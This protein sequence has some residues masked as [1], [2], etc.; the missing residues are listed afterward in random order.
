MKRPNIP[1]FKEKSDEFAITIQS[2][3]SELVDKVNGDI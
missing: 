2:M 1:T 3:Y